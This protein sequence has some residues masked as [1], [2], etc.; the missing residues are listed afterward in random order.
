MQWPVE[1]VKLYKFQLTCWRRKKKENKCKTFVIV[2][3]FVVDYKVDLLGITETW[4]HVEGSE[5]TI[6]ELCPNGYRLLHSPRSAG[7]GGGVGLLYKQG[8]GSKTRIFEHSFTSFECIDVTFVARK[9]LRAIVVYRPPGGASVGVFLEEFSSLLQETVICP[10]ELLIYG[11]FN[12]HMDDKADWDATRFGELLDLF[13]LKQH[14]CVPTHK[15]GHILDLVI[16]RNETEGA[17]GLKNV[18]VMEQFISDHKAVCFNLNLRKP[19]NE[20]RTV[21]SRKLKGFDF[22]AFNEMIGSSG[23]SDGCISQSVESLAKEY[24]E[25]LC[26]AL[27]KL[28]ELALL[29]FDLMLLGIIRRSLFR[30]RK[31][32]GSNVNGVRLVL[33]LTG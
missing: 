11:D 33:K 12:F 8:I 3:D 4:L 24:D 10:E 26:K 22:D 13:N 5:V 14:V 23:L 28:K 21:V 29:S 15:R 31:G 16:T 18:T 25:V 17:L 30:R 27:D 1:R 7:R 20:R 19:L 32:E 6:G 2:K 9:S